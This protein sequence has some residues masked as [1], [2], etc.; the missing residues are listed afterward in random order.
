[1]TATPDERPFV[2][3][4]SFIFA[5]A[6]ISAMTA[7]AIDIS[8]PGQPAMAADF[9]QRAEEAGVI[10]AAYFIGYGPG[11][12]LWGPMADKYGRMIPLYIGLA[13]FLITSILCATADSLESVSLYRLI[14]GIFGGSG[15]VIARAIARDQGGGKDT[16]KLMA[17]ILMIFGAAPLLAPMV[18][19]GILLVASWHGIFWFLAVFSVALMLVAKFYIA[20]SREGIERIVQKRVPLTFKLIVE[21]FSHRDFLMG[22]LATTAIF[23]GY[24]AIL[25]IG[26]AMTQNHYGV[27]PEQFGLLFAFSASSVMI[28]PA[29]TRKILNTYSIRTPL[30]IGAGISGMVGIAMLLCAQEQV[31]LAVLW[32]LVFLYCMSFSIMMPV[33]NAIALEP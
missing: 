25:G 10:I 1:M 2:Q 17:T 19:S 29:I 5:L 22:T 28:G 15:P 23:T 13:G 9:G 11:Q 24:A 16:A 33:A 31:P 3:R 30:K 27:S 18:G 4:P 7:T 20:P 14:Q 26:A 6:A 8:L 12:L 32:S 21:L